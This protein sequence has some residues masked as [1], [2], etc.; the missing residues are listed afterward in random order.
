MVSGVT[1][2]D[3]TDEAAFAP[4]TRAPQPRTR[5]RW[6]G[7][8]P[9]VWAP[10][11]R[12]V[13]VLLPQ[14]HGHAERRPMRLVGAHEPGYWR[15]DDELAHGTDY[16]FS[17]DGGPALPD[18]CSTLLP[19][20]LHGPSRVLDETFAWQDDAWR[21]VD[22]RRGV[23]LHLDIASVTAEGT[24]DGAAAL[25][26]AIAALGVDGV[27]L[28]PLTA[29]DPRTGPEAG[30]RL[31]AVHEP[32]GGPRALQ[33]FVDTAHRAGLAVVLDLPHRWSVADALGLHAFGPYATGARMGPRGGTAPA[34]DT[35]RINLDGSGSRG[36]RDFL[37]ADARRWLEEYHVDGLLLDVE[38]LVDRSA[39]PFLSELADAVQAV[40]AQS[41]RPRTLFMDGPGRSDRLTTIIEH[42]LSG[43]G[44]S[45]PLAALSDL[46]EATFPPGSTVARPPST[47]RR[48]QR[49]AARSASVLVGDLTRLPAAARAVPWPDP[50]AALPPADPDD[51]AALLAFAALA[52]TGLVLDTEHVPVRHHE[53]D[54]QRLVSWTRRLLTLRPSS[55]AD[56][57]EEVRPSP[58]PGVLVV[59]RGRSALVLVTAREPVEVD[60]ERHLDEPAG[61][62]RVAASWDPDGTHLLAGTLQVPGR[63]VVVLRADLEPAAEVD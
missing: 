45:A 20:G 3:P 21:G 34:R 24:L 26:P 35:P 25:L 44:G 38:A 57:A 36:S 30:V 29:F 33:R 63:T 27:E 43:A 61:T 52:G 56:L 60:L 11:A 10:R 23:L 42:I 58:A 13:E 15:A 47:F 4:G 37:I 19:H 62:W 18:P 50:R 49:A 32:Y 53:P 31:F 28:S 54:D 7:R 5:E 55:L 12:T 17:I 16:A 14:A 2:A 39:M 40:A 6:P 46:A 1:A 9:F 41:G 59:R 22:L 8:R 51:Q 48:A